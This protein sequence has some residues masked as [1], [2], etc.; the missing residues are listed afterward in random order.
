MFS[1]CHPKRASATGHLVAGQCLSMGGL[2]H[3][4]SKKRRTMWGLPETLRVQMT[5]SPCARTMVRTTWNA[6]CDTSL[7]RMIGYCGCVSVSNTAGGVRPQEKRRQTSQNFTETPKSF[8]NDADH[9]HELKESE[10]KSQSPF[11]VNK[12]RLFRNFKYL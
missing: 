7:V 11:L 5:P 1:N 10:H 8:E 6:G 3:L 12:W 9:E 2:R 4:V